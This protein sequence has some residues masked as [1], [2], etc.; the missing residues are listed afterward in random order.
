M[1]L[2]AGTVG[3]LQAIV[4][5]RRGTTTDLRTGK[6]LAEGFFRRDFVGCLSLL[7]VICVTLAVV[8]EDEA[9]G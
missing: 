9:T 1:L 7:S 3:A 4:E 6:K 8:D 5:V 2:K